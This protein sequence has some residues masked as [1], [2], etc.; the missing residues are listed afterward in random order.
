LAGYPVPKNLLVDPARLEWDY[1]SARPNL[2]HPGKLVSFGTSGHP[3]MPGQGTLTVVHVLAITQAIRDYRTA[4]G[5]QAV[6]P[7]HNAVDHAAGDQRLT[8]GGNDSPIGLKII[9]PGGGFAAWPTGTE[10]ISKIYTESFRGPAHLDAIV[11]EA[12]EM[13]NRALS[14]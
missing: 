5:T 3:G 11:S 4:H 6:E 10:D 12:R 2:D 8:D 1:Y 13:V 9:A 7:L 14:S